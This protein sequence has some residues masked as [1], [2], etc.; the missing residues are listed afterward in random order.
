MITCY[1]ICFKHCGRI[2]NQGELFL[3]KTSC[4][5]WH[6][7]FSGLFHIFMSKGSN[8]GFYFRI[9]CKERIVWYLTLGKGVEKGF[10]EELLFI[11]CATL[12]KSL[13]T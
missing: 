4:T 10:K 12:D 9:K 3:W 13:L 1:Q 7:I 5:S 2:S 11:K 8:L 6:P